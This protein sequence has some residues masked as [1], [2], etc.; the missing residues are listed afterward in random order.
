MEKCQATEFDSLK[1]KQAAKI[2]ERIKNRKEKWEILVKRHNNCLKDLQKQHLLERNK[3]QHC[4]TVVRDAHDACNFFG[5]AEEV[6]AE[7]GAEPRDLTGNTKLTWKKGHKDRLLQSIRF[8]TLE[9][10]NGQANRNRIVQRDPISHRAAGKQWRGHLK[11]SD[12][13][14]LQ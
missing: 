3:K 1:K 2:N 12:Y 13:P 9:R 10:V 7:E 14:A 4:Y 8:D 11:R 6:H 5:D